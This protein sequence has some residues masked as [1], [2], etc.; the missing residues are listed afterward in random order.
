MD[1]RVGAWLIGVAFAAASCVVPDPGSGDLLRDRS[2]RLASLVDVAYGPDQ[3]CPGTASDVD[4]GGSQTFDVFPATTGAGPRPVIIWLHGGGWDGGDKRDG[5]YPHVLAQT[6]RG[7]TVLNANYRLA[8]GTTRFP[9]PL[10]DV[11]RLVRWV[12]AHATDLDIDPRRVIIGG[13]SA[14]GNLASMVGVTTNGEFEPPLDPGVP[15]DA[16]LTRVNSSVA[17][18]VDIAGPVNYASFIARVPGLAVKAFSDYLGTTTDAAALRNAGPLPYVS[19]SAAPL[20]LVAGETD[21]ITPPTDLRDLATAY[22]DSGPKQRVWFDLVDDESHV[23]QGI[24][25]RALELFLDEPSHTSA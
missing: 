20:Y 11:K 21:P 15:A 17:A 22:V 7:Y 9:T 18:V 8:D 25:Q 24:H 1:V 13:H 12:K 6:N 10:H 19:A 23:P 16:A 2:T 4:C 5:V 3:G 14:G